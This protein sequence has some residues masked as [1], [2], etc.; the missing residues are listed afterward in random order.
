MNVPSIGASRRM[1]SS[2]LTSI[3]TRFKVQPKFRSLIAIKTQ[4]RITGSGHKPWIFMMS[5]QILNIHSYN[6]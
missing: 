4:T 5:E 2:Q 3:S 6:K 1:T